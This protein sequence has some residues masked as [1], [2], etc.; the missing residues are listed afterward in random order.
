M[1]SNLCGLQIFVGLVR[2]KQCKTMGKIWFLYMYIPWQI[3][4]KIIEKT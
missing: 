2:G 3:V 1:H 4:L